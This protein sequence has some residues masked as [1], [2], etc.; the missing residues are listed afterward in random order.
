MVR[1][2]AAWLAILA[3]LLPSAG[4]GDEVEAPAG[5][6]VEDRGE[7]IGILR[8]FPA[9]TSGGLRAEARTVV[10]DGKAWEEL[11]QRAN[12]HLAPVPKAPAVDFGKEMVAVAALGER[13]R[14]GASVEIVGVR[15]VE[16]TLRILYA[17]RE[18]A[19][20]EMA[21]EVL[22][23][24]WHAVVLPASGAPVEWVA[25]TAPGK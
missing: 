14:A 3:A 7:V 24:P 21:A 4:C 19:A 18:P 23:Q 16:G 8:A 20:G 10:R 11:W 22:T 15:L 17:A 9:S 13:K 2:A 6:R 1:R 12:A 5:D 25:W